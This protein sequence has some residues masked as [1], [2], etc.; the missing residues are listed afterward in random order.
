LIGK[1][2][3]KNSLPSPIGALMALKRKKAL[4]EQITKLQRS[5]LTIEQ[6]VM[7]VES[8]SMSLETMNAMRSGAG[9]LR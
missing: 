9:S 6:Q 4:A 2:K 8:A 3:K 5:K 1:R 7:T